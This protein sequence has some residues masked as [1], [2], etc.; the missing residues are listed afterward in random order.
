MNVR[1]KICGITRR[2]DAEHAIA[3]GAD[4]LGLV[5]YPGSPRYVELEAACRLVEGLPP[6]VSLVGLFVNADAETIRRTAAACRLD[7]VQLHGDESPEDCR[8]PGLKVIK[9]L[10]VR[11]R[12]SLQ[13]VDDY[14]VDGLLLDAWCPESYGGTGKTFDW[15]LAAGLARRRPLILA[16]GLNPDNVAEAVRRVAPFAVDV[17]SGVESSPGIKD[18]AKV[19]A[20]IANA[21]KNAPAEDGV[22][23]GVNC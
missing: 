1:V 22:G 18:P 11:D 16:G 20:F 14:R 3:C 6:F 9:A 19:A 15:E 12:Q 7:L 10:R 2:Q 23:G 4:A 21:R 13:R 17:S 8:L 5:F